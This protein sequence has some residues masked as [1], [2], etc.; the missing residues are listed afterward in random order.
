MKPSASH[1]SL[2]WGGLIPLAD[3]H[4]DPARTGRVN[5]GALGLAWN[6]PRLDVA[7]HQRD[8]AFMFCTVLH[9]LQSPH[10]VGVIVRSHVAFGG[11]D[12]V[13]L[14]YSQPWRFGK[15]T[16]AFSR[17]LEKLCR[18]IYL[19]TDNEFFEWCNREQLA[20]VALEITP[21]AQPIDATVFPERAAFVVGRESCG[22][23]AGFLDRCDHVVTIPQFGPVGSLNVAVAC[24]LAM[25]ECVRGKRP[26]GPVVGR[27]YSDVSFAE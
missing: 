12:I 3:G 2:S 18:F 4:I 25:Y 22:L 6:L 5:D 14:G 20:S 26:F 13:M 7:V 27:K 17:R 9:T 1:A 19:R 8:S 11:A 10:N 15:S 23:A 24:S 21:S 16:Q